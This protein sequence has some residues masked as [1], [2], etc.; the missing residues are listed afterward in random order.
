MAPDPTFRYYKPVQAQQYAGARPAYPP[1]LYKHIFAEHSASGGGFGFL[2]DVGCGPG[3][4]TRDLASAFEHAV[5]VDPG[6]EMINVARERCGKTKKGA[7]IQYEVW[8]SE[9]VA[10]APGVPLGE[11]DLI[12]AATAVHWFDMKKFW[13]QAAQL[14][15]PGGTV[16]LWTKGMYY[17]RMSAIFSSLEES[18]S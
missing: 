4:A 12:T 17:T 15:R 3:T 14:L 1:E 5:G 7:A 18:C 8:D 2:L 16:A 11:V 13:D 10:S 6:E 9:R